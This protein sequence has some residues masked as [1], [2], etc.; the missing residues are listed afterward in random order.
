MIRAPVDF[1][2][3]ATMRV[4]LKPNQSL[5]IFDRR[6]VNRGETTAVLVL[7]REK[8]GGRIEVDRDPYPLKST[9]STFPDGQSPGNIPA[10][11]A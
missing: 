5:V 11:N 1:R 3:G 7:L 6:I 2:R 9:P 4:E 10:R 8:G